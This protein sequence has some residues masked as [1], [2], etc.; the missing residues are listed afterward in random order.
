M[1]L[2]VTNTSGVSLDVPFPVSKTLAIGASATVGASLRDL[3]FDAV[4]GD[5]AWRTLTGLKQAGKITFTLVNDPADLSLDPLAQALLG[6][7]MRGGTAVAGGAGDVVVAF[8][9]PLPAATYQIM[10]GNGSAALAVVKTAVART[11]NGFTLNFGAAG[12]CD[13]TAILIPT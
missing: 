4:K 9:V 13:W 2:T 5:E 11:V 10:L 1:L 7:N 12:S 6:G 3:L 8:T